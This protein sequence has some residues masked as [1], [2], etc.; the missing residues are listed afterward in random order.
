MIFRNGTLCDL[1]STVTIAS[2][3]IEGNYDI[4]VVPLKW[5]MREMLTE[6]LQNESAKRTGE[7]V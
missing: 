6:I 2:K 5:E 7:N 3:N 4:L 1:Q